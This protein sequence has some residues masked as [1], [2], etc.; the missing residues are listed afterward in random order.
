MA[1][2]RAGSNTAA[3]H[4]AVVDTVIRTDAAGT[5]HH[6]AAYLA[7]LGVEFS[8]GASWVL[9]HPRRVR[10]AANLGMDPGVSGA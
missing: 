10:A 3:D 7:G 9:R 6:F 4:V 1:E 8:V 5:S 2:L